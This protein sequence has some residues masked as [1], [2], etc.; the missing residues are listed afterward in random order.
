[1]V[2]ADREDVEAELVGELGLLEEVAHPLAGA[3]ASREIDEG[4]ESEF[5]RPDYSK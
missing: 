2:L 1:V 5:H 3:D 4:G